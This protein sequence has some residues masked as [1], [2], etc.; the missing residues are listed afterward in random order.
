MSPN[1]R[2][3]SFSKAREWARSLK[4]KSAR[5]WLE[6]VKYEEFPDDIP[7]SPNTVYKDEW[8]GYNDWLREDER[9]IQNFHFIEHDEAKSILKKH[10]IQSRAAYFNL[11]NIKNYELPKRPYIV[12]KDRGWKGWAE[13]LSIDDYSKKMG[14]LFEKIQDIDALSNQLNLSKA[15]LTSVVSFIVLI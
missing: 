4:L 6:Y 2:F 9:V 12:Y 15:S 1:R 3:I 5:E 10:N 14:K 13:Y 7:K 11:S 8:R